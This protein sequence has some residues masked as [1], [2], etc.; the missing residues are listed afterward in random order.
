MGYKHQKENILKVGYN[1]IRKNGYHNV[2]I[3][4]ILKEAGI[5][6]GSFYNFFESKED[7]AKQVIE[8]YGTNNA[9]FLREYFRDSNESPISSLKSFYSMMIGINETDEFQSG[10]VINKMNLEVGRNN[11]SF[12]ELLDKHFTNWIQIIAEV[13]QKGQ[14]QGEITKKQ[15]AIEIAEYL[16]AGMYG[17]FSRSNVLQSR[18]YLD[19]WLNLT[20][21]LIKA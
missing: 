14:D 10:C 11:S 8:N 13:V 5:P 1:V 12:A 3:N 9:N 4:Q 6:K 2:G 20:F 18:D 7:F 17:G 19:R 15:N 16:H 21:E